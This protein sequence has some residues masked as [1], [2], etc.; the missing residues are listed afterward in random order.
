VAIAERWLSARPPLRNAL[1]AT[2]AVG[3]VAATSMVVTGAYYEGAR[4]TRTFGF[5]ESAL[6][7][8]PAAIDFLDG[9]ASGDRIFN[10]DGLG[11]YLLWRTF[12]RRRVFIDGRLQVYPASVYSEYQEVLDDPRRFA[13]LAAR[14]GITAAILYHPAPGRLELARAIA[15]VPGWRIVYLDGGAVILRNEGRSPAGMPHL[16]AADQ[17]VASVIDRLLA[18]LRPP[19]EAAIAHYQRGR[20]IL[21]LLGGEGVATARADFQSALRLWPT[22]QEAAVG[23][24]ATN[25]SGGRSR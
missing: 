2:I 13:P 7:F 23:L 9:H 6:G 19:I 1:A 3:F 25:A 17:Q 16:G 10:D 22:L 20:A 5:G 11:G 21:Y 14:Y 12:P 18:A 24:A 8:P 4:L 15:S